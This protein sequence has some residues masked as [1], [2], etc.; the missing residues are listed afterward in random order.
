VSTFATSP[1]VVTQ[2]RP[3]LRHH[4]GM[5]LDQF[6]SHLSVVGRS[7]RKL[8]LAVQEPEEARV[9]EFCP[10][11]LPVEV[12]EGHEKIGH[13][14]VLPREERGQAI[15][16]VARVAHAFSIVHDPDTPRFTFSVALC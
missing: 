14:I 3:S 10:G 6:R 15:G 13:G 11:P 12:G 8:E 2:R 4:L 5:L 16:E 1:T 7:L 9:P